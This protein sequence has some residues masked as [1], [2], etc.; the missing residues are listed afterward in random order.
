[1]HELGVLC[2][3]VKLVQRTAEKNKIQKIKYFTLEIGENSG[4]VPMFFEKLFPVAVDG[5]NL[6]QEAELRMEIVD[7]KGLTVK[8]IGY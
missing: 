6:F 7:G 1:M 8:E 4:Y 3:A 5:I 2:H